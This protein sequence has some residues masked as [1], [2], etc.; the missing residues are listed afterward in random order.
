[1]RAICAGLLLSLAASS[2]VCAESPADRIV[3]VLS[4]ACVAPATPEGMLDAGNRIALAEGWTLLHAEPAPM[5]MMH[6]EHGPKISFESAWEFRLPD[7][8]KGRV[9]ISILRP[10]QTAVKH[11][12]CALS[13]PISVTADAIQQTLEHR[14]SALVVKD[15][16]QWSGS[17]RWFFAAE[18]QHGNC[19]RTITLFERNEPVLLYVDGVYPNNGQWSAPLSQSICRS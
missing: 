5:P 13:Y 2:A 17:R 15:T 7:G 1:M 12:V 19:G 16:K 4:E 10:E 3:R 18:R 14:L 9:S 6:N 8:S 11:N